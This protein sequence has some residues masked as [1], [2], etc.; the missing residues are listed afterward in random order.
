[1]NNLIKRILTALL[2]GSAVIGAIFWNEYSAA[3]LFLIITIGAVWEYFVL[4]RPLQNDSSAWYRFFQISISIGLFV[5]HTS[6]AFEWLA[7]KY[8]ILYLPVI[9]SLFIA[10]L[11]SNSKS[12]IQ[13]LGI[14]L[15]AIVYIVIP[16][17][18]GVF[19]VIL[20]PQIIVGALLLT[21]FYDIGAFFVGRSLGR[22][23]L[24]KRISPKKTFEG[25]AGGTILCF[26]LSYPISIYCDILD[27]QNWV[28][29]A[30]LIVVF[31]TLGD[32]V[33]SMIK[34]SLAIKDSG[35]SLPG[36][37]GILDRFDSFF[38]SIPFIYVFVML[39]I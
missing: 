21:W 16:L 37:G 25:V 28:T 14:N 26:I 15:L 39:T 1:M 3:L 30:G 18:L 17:S 12:P 32:L 2:G 22:T 20:S 31:G 38:L 7:A 9:F 29:I 36:H 8:F 6:I 19:L 5:F 10:E 35:A 33:E 11:F 34:R 23:P 4:M 24:F 13:N 27:L